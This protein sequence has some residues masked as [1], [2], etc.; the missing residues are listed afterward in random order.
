MKDATSLK[1][2][3]MMD[4]RKNCMPINLKTFIGGSQM[5]SV[6]GCVVNGL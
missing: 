1:M 2:L 4:I 5:F 3:V 6:T